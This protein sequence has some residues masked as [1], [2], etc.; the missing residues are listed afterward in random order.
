MSASEST[1]AEIQ[2]YADRLSKLD[3][4]A[5]VVPAQ[6]VGDGTWCIDVL[7]DQ[8]ALEESS[9]NPVKDVRAQDAPAPILVGGQSAEQVD[10]VSSIANKLPAFLVPSLM[11]LLGHRNW[12]APHW[13][14]RVHDRIGVSEGDPE[15]VERA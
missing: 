7:P 2:Q 10:Q 1:G 3:H 15:T 12:R 13:L 11:A 9:R 8:R 6:F 5:S 4:V 14:R